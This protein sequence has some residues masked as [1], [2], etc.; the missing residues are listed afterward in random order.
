MTALDPLKSSRAGTRFRV[1]PQAPYVA[2]FNEPETVWVSPPAGTVGPGPSDGRLYVIEPVGKSNPYE[3]TL[4]RDGST[5]LHMP[6]WDGEIKPP[7]MPD[8][9][10]HFD[11]LEPGTTEFEVAH[12]YAGVRRVLDIWEHYFGRRIEWHFRGDYERLEV[13]VLPE[14]DNA[15][16]GYGFMEIGYH[17]EPSGD[18]RPFTLN[19][20]VIA[21]E[22][23]HA[24]IYSEI[25]V[26][27]AETEQDEYFGFHESAADTV[28]LISALHFDSVVDELLQNSRGNLYTVNRLNRIGELTENKQLRLA[29][30]QARLS[31]F[32]NGWVDEHKLSEPLTGA[33]FDIL[34]DIFHEA[35]LELG[36]IS[37]QVEDLADRLEQQPEHADM[38]QGLFD[39][40]YAGHH[41][42]FK[43]TLLAARDILGYYLAESWS[44]LSPD[45]LGYDDVAATLLAVDLEATAGRYESLIARNMLLR[46][47]NL[48]RVG[49]RLSP[50]AAKSQAFSQGTLMLEQATPRRKPCYRERM[51]A[52]RNRRL[53]VER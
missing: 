43:D 25:G 18:V 27:S 15:I 24:I 3:T 47:I 44:R 13:V 10:G 41:D 4:R 39:K 49:P 1:F 20:D 6:P 40:A 29:A 9:N 33:V 19:F 51:V 35:L 2:P 11:H 53:P 5:V 46:D 48:V 36:L 8:P 30:N 28:A 50:P 12:V 17:H 32:A 42:G 34:V 37:P 45:F 7:A 31:D 38:I 22:V 21:H 14:L 26:P 52:A 16:M 23:G